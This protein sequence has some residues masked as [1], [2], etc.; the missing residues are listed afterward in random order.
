MLGL[1]RQLNSRLVDSPTDT[2]KIEVIGRER[3]GKTA[4]LKSLYAGPLQEIL[5]SGLRFGVTDPM[6]MAEIIRKARED[7]RDMRRRGIVSTVDCPVLDYSVLKAGRRMCGLQ[8]REAVGQVLSYT[9][10]ESA[11]EDQERCQ[12]YRQHLAE[13]S[14]LWQVIPCLPASPTQGEVQR[15][16][17]DVLLTLTYA[18][19]ALKN[20]RVSRPAALALIVTKIDTRYE[21]AEAAKTRMPGE[22]LR[23]LK[24]QVEDLLA[25]RDLADAA[26]FPVSAYGFGTAELSATLGPGKEWI[27]KTASPRPFN[28]TPLILWS[29]TA[30][31]RNA[32][33]GVN[34]GRE[35]ELLQILRHLRH[36]LNALPNC[37]YLPLKGE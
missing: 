7:Y 37:W 19:D 14:V 31:L 18:L 16:R 35:P 1:L 9:T 32:E 34:G 2:I 23:W 21:S 28:L 29:L 25:S 36:D 10:T 24:H 5:P 3:A 13:A 8:I 6:R 26:C 12:Q 11:P 22:M 17:D 20:R 30:G 27:L 4:M 33:V 15:L